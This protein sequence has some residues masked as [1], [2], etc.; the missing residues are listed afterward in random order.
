MYFG[1]QAI[2]SPFCRVGKNHIYTFIRYYWQ[3]ITK[4][5]AVYGVYIYGFGQPYPFAFLPGTTN[6]MGFNLLS[7]LVRP[8]TSPYLSSFSSLFL[9]SLSFQ[10]LSSDYAPYSFSLFLFK[11]CQATMLLI[12]SFSFFSKLVKR[13]CS[14]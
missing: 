5:T 8:A 11:A 12:P 4:Y 6:R 2:H 9:P 14:L 3:E 10:S 7:N 1:S 13:L